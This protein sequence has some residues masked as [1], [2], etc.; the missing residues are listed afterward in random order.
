MKNIKIRIKSE[1]HS[2]KVQDHLF[3]LGYEW[4]GGGNR[5]FPNYV[6]A[7]T[8]YEEEDGNK[9]IYF[10][11]K[12]SF[13]DYE[14]QEVELVTEVTEDGK[15]CTYLKE[16]EPPL[17]KWKFEVR[18]SVFGNLV[19]GAVDVDSGELIANFINLNITMGTCGYAKNILEEEYDISGYEWNDDGSIK[20][21]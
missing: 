17:K 11:Y 3:S 1:D 15:V 10:C 21:N 4:K 2:R 9:Y 18:T 12:D 13:D 6:E 8:A 14:I 16:V 19:L 5:Y 7:F 20:I